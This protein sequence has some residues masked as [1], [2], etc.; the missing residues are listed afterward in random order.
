MNL[1]P[2]SCCYPSGVSSYVAIE[3][4]ERKMVQEVTNRMQWLL[5]QAERKIQL[6]VARIAAQIQAAEAEETAV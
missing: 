1:S 3:A 5:A 4:S 6:T 2:W